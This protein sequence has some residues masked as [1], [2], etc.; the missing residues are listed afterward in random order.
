MWL[1][2]LNHRYQ[3]VNISHIHYDDALDILMLLKEMISK[4]EFEKYVHWLA[5]SNKGKKK[6]L[7]M[8]E[9]RGLI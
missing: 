9:E 7:K 2:S 8:M 1:N 3:T 6:L 4:A 5:K